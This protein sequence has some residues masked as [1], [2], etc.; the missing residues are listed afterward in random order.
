MTDSEYLNI[1]LHN[2]IQLLI[3]DH[4]KHKVLS[5]GALKHLNLLKLSFLFA[6]IYYFLR[7]PEI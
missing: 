7:L 1:N 4:I 3:Y 5:F 2:T 6:L